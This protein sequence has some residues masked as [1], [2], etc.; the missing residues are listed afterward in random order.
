MSEPPAIYITAADRLT[1]GLTPE[2]IKTFATVLLQG[3]GLFWVVSDEGVRPLSRAEVEKSVEDCWRLWK[4][5]VHG[6]ERPVRKK[7]RRPRFR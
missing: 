7:A 1:S 5:A 2:Q 4:L 6:E 3:H